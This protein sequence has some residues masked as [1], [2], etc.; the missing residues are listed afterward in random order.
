MVDIDCLLDSTEE[1]DL[2]GGISSDDKGESRG[3]N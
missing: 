2:L 1:N 3:K